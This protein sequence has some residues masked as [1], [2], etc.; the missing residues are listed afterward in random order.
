MKNESVL[1]KE[2][3]EKEVQRLRNVVSGNSHERTLS[4]VGYTK[5]QEFYKEG[6]IW[7]E[8]GR[9]WT[10]KDGIKQNITKLDRA[11]DAVMPL[12]CPSCKK[13]MNKTI[14]KDI[15][16]HF[17]HCFDCHV[18]FEHELKGKGLWEVYTNNMHNSMVDETI[19]G[20]KK[21]VEEL[22]TESNQGF[23]SEQGEVQKWTGGINKELAQ[24]SL[25]E[26]IEYLESLKK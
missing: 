4:G 14:D 18:D 11:K 2:F 6:D 24:K 16:T 22:L 8:N 3:T 17:R 5:K 21:W 1:K 7:T 25:T 15:Y 23:V 10:I 26:T 12:F 9:E 20:Y 19:E 13:V